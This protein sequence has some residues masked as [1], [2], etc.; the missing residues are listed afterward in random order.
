MN[1]ARL[2]QLPAEDSWYSIVLAI[3]AANSLVF[4]TLN[5]PMARS[6]YQSSPESMQA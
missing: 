5:R 4:D 1:T 3:T 2:V 6:G